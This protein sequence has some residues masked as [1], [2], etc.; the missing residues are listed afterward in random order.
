M[1]HVPCCAG[2]PVPRPAALDPSGRI[3]APAVGNPTGLAAGG[4]NRH[5][6]GTANSL[7]VEFLH[8]AEDRRPTAPEGA[9]NLHLV[10]VN[11]PTCA[12]GVDRSVRHVHAMKPWSDGA[13]AG[14]P[15]GVGAPAGAR[16]DGADRSADRHPDGLGGPAG[17][18]SGGAQTG[19]IPF[20]VLGQA[21]EGRGRSAAAKRSAQERAQVPLSRRSRRRTSADT[22]RRNQLI[23][24]VLKRRATTRSTAF[25]SGPEEASGTSVSFSIARRF[26]AT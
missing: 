23:P 2:P 8:R 19:S 20:S 16:L 7:T 12:L 21:A 22:P 3:L 10:S 18:W 5:G 11:R 14:H 6:D 26:A 15:D 25:S 13:G 17:A 9:G 24:R 1:P 4:S